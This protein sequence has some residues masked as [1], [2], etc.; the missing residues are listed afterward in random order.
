[1][2]ETVRERIL[3][4]LKTT[5]EEITKDNGYRSDVESVQR[6]MQHGNTLTDVPC[7]IINSGPDRWDDDNTV[8]MSAV[9]TVFLDIWIRQD[10]DDTV[11]TDKIL[12]DLLADVFEAIK[13][14]TTLDGDA[15][16]IKFRSI[17][18]FETIEGQPHAG[19]TVELEIMYRFKQ[20]DPEKTG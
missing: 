6:Y 16:D 15:L 9:F 14:D 8:I 18:P 13:E 20:D 10:E 3:A 1:M 12:N 19:V 2:A 5:L 7:I 17:D 4:T 11:P